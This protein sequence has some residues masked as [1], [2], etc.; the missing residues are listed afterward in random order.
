MAQAFES[1]RAH[2]GIRVA[3]AAGALAAAGLLVYFGWRRLGGPQLLGGGLARRRA[4][5]CTRTSWGDVHFV[6]H[7]H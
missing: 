2:S 5:L 1:A 4:S 6:P 3:L 7:C